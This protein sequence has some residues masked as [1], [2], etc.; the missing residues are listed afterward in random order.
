MI[1]TSFCICALWNFVH[2]WD[3]L[4][5]AYNIDGVV[6]KDDCSASRVISSLSKETSAQK[7]QSSTFHRRG[8]PQESTYRL[9]FD[10]TSQHY[11]VSPAADFHDRVNFVLQY[12]LP[13]VNVFESNWLVVFLIHPYLAPAIQDEATSSRVRRGW[14]GWLLWMSSTGYFFKDHQFFR[15]FLLP[16]RHCS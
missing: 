11:R 10:W 8:F 2:Q 1:L 9:Q 15:L 6:T 5:A 4:V 7:D 13:V 14:K 16:R 3:N 12:F